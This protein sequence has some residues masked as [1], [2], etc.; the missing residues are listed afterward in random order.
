MESMERDLP[1]NFDLGL[2]PAMILATSCST[3]N[4]NTEKFKQTFTLKNK[5]NTR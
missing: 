5:I 2:A 1:F 4:D 3:P